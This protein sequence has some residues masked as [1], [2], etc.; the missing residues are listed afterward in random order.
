LVFVAPSPYCCCCCA[1]AAA[2]AAAA[3][4]MIAHAPHHDVLESHC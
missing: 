2:A 4:T 3:V 1:A